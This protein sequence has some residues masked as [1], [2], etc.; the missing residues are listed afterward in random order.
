MESNPMTTTVTKV[1]S[2]WE[3]K[4]TQEETARILAVVYLSAFDTLSKYGE[5]ACEEFETMVRRHKID[6]YRHLGVQTPIDLVRAIS[7]TEHNVFGSEIEIFGDEKKACLR[8][9][10]C[11]MWEATQK[12]HVMTQ[13]KEEMMG[14]N[15][16]NSYIK[17]AEEFGFKFEGKM[18]DDCYILTFTK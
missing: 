18:E 11:G 15:C 16:Q 4:K 8:Y 7:E 6:H 5:K 17:I 12:L 9:K 14:K 3:T 1:E 13:E 2:K 10:K